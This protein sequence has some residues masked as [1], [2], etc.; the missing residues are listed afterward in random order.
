[1]DGLEDEDD[2]TGEDDDFE[3]HPINPL[4][5][6]LFDEVEEL[7][8]Q[9]GNLTSAT[10]L[11]SLRIEH[12]LYEARMQRATIEA[13]VREEMSREADVRMRSVVE[14]YERRLRSES[15]RH[16]MK[17]DAK[18]DMLF[19][20]PAKGR[21]RIFQSPD[22]EE[23]EESMVSFHDLLPLKMLKGYPASRDH[24]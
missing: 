21:T 3:D 8:L 13:Q 14:M 12:Q 1:M 19:N 17:T 10:W 22:S 9:V 15:A 6:A 24:F 16:E 23:A 11:S 4:V 2:E 20:S 7:R 18:I 5:D